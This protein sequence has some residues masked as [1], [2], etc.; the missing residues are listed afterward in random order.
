MFQ[1]EYLPYARGDGFQAIEFPYAGS[2][3]S[4][5]V[6][7][8]DEGQFEA[9]EEGLDPDALNAA[10]DQMD[11][12]EVL[13]YLPKFEFDYDTSLAE[14]L[15]SMGMEDAFDPARAD[16]SGMVEGT[17]PE[18]LFIGDVLHKAFI[19]VDEN[20]TEAAAA[21]VVGMVGAA[22]PTEEPPEVRIDRPFIFAIRDT[23][24][25][26]VLFMGRVMNPNG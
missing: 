26:T 21:T 5:T 19:S 3:L 25:G 6:I 13:V 10:I 1:R 17:P 2:G 11:S 16:F 4:F 12:T 20:G 22:A 23:E 15:R 14:T 8:P 9:F 7:L 18:A 24:T